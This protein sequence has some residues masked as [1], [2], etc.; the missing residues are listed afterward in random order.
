MKEY[1]EAKFQGHS[2]LIFSLDYSYQPEALATL[3]PYPPWDPLNKEQG[4]LHSH[5]G[6]NIHLYFL[7]PPGIET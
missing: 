3:P 2:F 5:F 6:E 7:P 1:G 4:K